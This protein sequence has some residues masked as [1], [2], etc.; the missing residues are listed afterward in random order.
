[1]HTSWFLRLFLATP[2][3]LLTAYLK[4]TAA[5]SDFKTPRLSEVST[6]LSISRLILMMPFG[7]ASIS[8][9][10]LALS[11]ALI[12]DSLQSVSSDTASLMSGSDAL[13]SSAISA[14]ACSIEAFTAAALSGATIICAVHSLGMALSFLPPSIEAIATG[15]DASRSSLDIRVLALP[16]PLSISEPECPPVRPD[17]LTVSF[18][19]LT[20]SLSTGSFTSVLHPPA[21][22]ASITPSSSLSI[23][24]SFF[25]LSIDTSMP[26]APSMPTS[27]HTVHTN[28][29]RGCERLSSSKIASAYATAIP[30]SPPSVVPFAEIKS[31]SIKRSRPSSS[32]SLSQ[33]GAFSQTISMCPC[34]MIGSTSSYPSDASFMIITL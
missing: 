17:K 29:R 23:L 21:Q 20:V 25:P 22:L 10:T 33:S 30:S 12:A 5:S 7:S 1:M 27:S 32:I 28:S 31:P 34:S 19:P 16:L 4:V 15:A 8:A 9:I 14:A 3:E 24:R 26:V 2:T 13:N 11:F 18:V 6:S